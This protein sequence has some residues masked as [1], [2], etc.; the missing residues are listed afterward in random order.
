MSAPALWIAVPL[1]VGAMALS[2]STERAAAL[3]G[4]LT[5]LTLALIALVVPIDAALLFGPFSL[6]IGST[7]SLLGRSLVIPASEAPL[8]AM[9][10]GLG[11]MWFFGA[12]AAGVAH[13]L[14]PVGMMITG[15]LIASLAVQPFL[16]AAL[17]IEMAALAAVPLLA[18]QGKAP[19]RAVVKFLTYQTLGMP[20]ILLAGWLLAGVETSPGDLVLT[21]QATV[22]LSLGFAFLLAIFP[23]GDWIPGLMEESHPYVTGFVLWLLPNTILVFGLS[24]LDSYA[25]LRASPEIVS[26]LRSLGLIMLVSGGIWSA[27]ERNLGRMMGHAA[28]AETGLIFLA[29]SLATANGSDTIFPFF[30]PRGLGMALWALSLAVVHRENAALDF[31]TLKRIGSTH[32]WAGAGLVLASLSAAGFP[33]LAGFPPRIDVWNGL[34]HVSGSSALWFLLGLTG[35]MI[36]A[37]RQLALVVGASSEMPTFPQEDVLQRG[38]LAAGMLALV[39]LGLYPRAASFLIVRLPLMFEHLAR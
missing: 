22:M 25:W 38:M 20:C 8:L 14:V 24:F 29:T 33:L 31:S 19:G 7:A 37:V 2:L 21:I 13:R 5:C 35:L 18:P 30:I 12:E 11:A 16:Y 10:F 39:V 28:V 15:L 36:G 26:G 1:V 32:P 3:V 23:L 4:G 34:A 27:L 17:L 6:K 9:L